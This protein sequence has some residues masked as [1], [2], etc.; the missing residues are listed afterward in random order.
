MAENNATWVLLLHQIFQREQTS[1][2]LYLA[3][4]LIAANGELGERT[5]KTKSAER[6]D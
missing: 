5:Q 2:Y 6:T 3:S 1:I 4:S